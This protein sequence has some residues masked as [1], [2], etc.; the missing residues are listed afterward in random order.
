MNGNQFTINVVNAFIDNGVG[1]NPAG[2]VLDADG[3]D[4]QTKQQIA[5]QA[6]LSETAFVSASETAVF[7]LEFFTPTRQIAHCGHATVA[8]FSYLAQQGRVSGPES[9]KETID[10]NRDIFLKGDLA[11][12]EQRA[13]RYQSVTAADSNINVATILSSLGLTTS[14]LLPGREPLVV[15]T[16]NSF[17]VIP[18]ASEAALAG[19][20]PDQTAIEQISE[21]LDLIGYYP[22]TPETQVPGRDAAARMFAPRY[23]IPEESATGMAA[24]PLACYLFDQLDVKKSRFTIE[25]GRLMMP[26]SPSEIIVEITLHE[27]EI[28]RLMAG[29]RARLMKQIQ[30]E[31]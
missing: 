26:P 21:A 27:E 20:T 4:R 24:G 3:L 11:F 6:G 25:Q 22:F 29:G 18:L 10:G 15:N 17:L 19:I 13:P 12:M 2:V 14:H 31:T 30:V 8:A 23:G 1:G 9:S 7:K 16:G 5:A 28:T